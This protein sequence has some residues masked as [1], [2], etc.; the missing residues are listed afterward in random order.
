MLRTITAHEG[1]VRCLDFLN[2]QT[3]VSGSRDKS[4]RTWSLKDDLIEHTMTFVGHGTEVRCVAAHGTV[5]A[6]ASVD[7]EAR[8]WNAETGEC[9]HILRGHC[10]VVSY[11]KYDGLRIVTSGTDGDIRVWNPTTGYVRLNRAQIKRLD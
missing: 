1:G 6:S 7:G 9:L 10:T 11:I 2:D 3:F 8:V 4:L 5:I